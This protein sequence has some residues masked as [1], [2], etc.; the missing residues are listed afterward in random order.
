MGLIWYTADHEEPN[1]MNCI[2]LGR[3]E[4]CCVNNCGAEHSWSHYLRMVHS[5]DFTGD[6]DIM[7][8]CVMKLL[9]LA[10]DL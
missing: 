2:H 8:Y 5:D 4:A 9:Q 3:G 1:C 10:K 7:E 6:M